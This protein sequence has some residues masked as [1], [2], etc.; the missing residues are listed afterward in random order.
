MIYFSDISELNDHKYKKNG[1]VRDEN[2]KGNFL[3]TMKEFLSFGTY[4]N[5]CFNAKKIIKRENV[6]DPGAKI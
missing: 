5:Q 6:W 3:F 1:T 4:F 2:Y